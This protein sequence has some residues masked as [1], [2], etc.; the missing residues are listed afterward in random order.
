MITVNIPWNEK[1]NTTPLWNDITA[2][3]VEKF[4][5][6]GDKYRTE[7]S[8]ECMKFHFHNDHEGLMCKLLVSEYV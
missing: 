2:T 1:T 5:L 7:V 6:P 8:T 4:G 3:I